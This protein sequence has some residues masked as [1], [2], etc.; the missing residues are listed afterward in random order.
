MLLQG[1]SYYFVEHLFSLAVCLF[2]LKFVEYLVN[3]TLLYDEFDYEVFSY[4]YQVLTVLVNHEA[5]TKVSNQK[6]CHLIEAILNSKEQSCPA[7][8]ILM[9]HIT[10]KND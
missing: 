4:V 10:T 2:N 8:N 9:V 1:F 3:L 6:Y 7:C 5:V